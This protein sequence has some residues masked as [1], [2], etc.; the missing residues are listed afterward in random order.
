VLF[1]ADYTRA[2]RA[3]GRADAERQA[4]EI[5]ALFQ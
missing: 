5:L 3:L 4:D 1:D 2:L